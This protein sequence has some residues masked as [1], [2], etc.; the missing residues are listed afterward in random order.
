MP[1]HALIVSLSPERAGALWAQ[2]P[3]ADKATITPAWE[4]ISPEAF[5]DYEPRDVSAVLVDPEVLEGEYDEAALRLQAETLVAE[6]L[7]VP[8]LRLA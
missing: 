6:S 5:L 4:W 2:M 8:L 3:K 1:N 7:T